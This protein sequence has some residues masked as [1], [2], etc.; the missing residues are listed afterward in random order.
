MPSRF[1]WAGGAG[2]VSTNNSL[3]VAGKQMS[4]RR[5]GKAIEKLRAKGKTLPE[6][7]SQYSLLY[8]YFPSPPQSIPSGLSTPVTP[9]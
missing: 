7:A 1:V 8:S 4:I 5:Y 3:N 9:L 6:P 2:S